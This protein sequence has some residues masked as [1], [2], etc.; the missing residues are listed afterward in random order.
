MEAIMAST[1]ERGDKQGPN[2]GQKQADQERKGETELRHMGDH[3]EPNLGQKKARQDRRS[4]SEL[5]HMGDQKP[6]GSSH[7]GSPR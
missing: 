2:L 4:E 6:A 5:Q 7:K 1:G 3:E